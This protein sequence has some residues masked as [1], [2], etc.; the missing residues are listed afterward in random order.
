MN[1]LP[2]FEPGDTVRF[3][4]GTDEWKV[5]KRSMSTDDDYHR[6]YFGNNRIHARSCDLELVRKAPRMVKKSGWINIYKTSVACSNYT[7]AQASNVY[8]N[9]NEAQKWVDPDRIACVE[10]HWE[11]VQDG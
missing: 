3:K 10:I 1:N 6:I 8:R 4:G 5:N 2:K 11:E 7:V 9:Q